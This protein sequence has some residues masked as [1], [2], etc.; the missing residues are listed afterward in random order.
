MIIGVLK[1][2]KNREGRVALIPSQVRELSRLGHKVFAQQDAGILSG[3]SNQ[4]YSRSGALI[5]NLKQTLIQKSEL[6]I[7]V[8]EP[9]IVEINLMRAGQMIF[10]YLHLAAIPKTLKKILQKKIIAL[11]YE[12]LQLKD[13]SLPLLAPMSEIAGKLATQNGAQFLRVD[14]GGRGVLMGGTKMVKPAHVLILGAGIVGENAAKIAMGMGAKTTILDI[15][16]NKL[17]KIRKKY[18]H[19]FGSLCQTFVSSRQIISQLVPKS[20]LIIGAVLIPGA[21]APKLVTRQIVKK[22]K[23]G[24]VIVDVSVDQG[25]CVE[26]SEVTSHQNPI[27]IKHGVLH[28]GVPNIPGSVPVT[29]TLA[30]THETFKYIKAL[31]QWGLVEACVKY[32][33]L[34]GAIQCA[35]G[36]IIHHAL[37]RL[38]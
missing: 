17:L 27:V 29:G 11:G 6:L 33:E 24:S 37:R 14:Y 2:S 1:E 30:L 12:T 9:T 36:K 16:K 35:D 13:G 31:A 32:P 4:D 10:C 22:M 15:S 8:K 5:V 28:Y 18:K 26:T 21:R 25:G 38:I 20:D 23:R 19:Q 3:F 7:K 34:K